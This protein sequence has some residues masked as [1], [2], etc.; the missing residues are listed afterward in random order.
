MSRVFRQCRKSKSVKTNESISP[1]EGHVRIR[2]PEGPVSALDG[3]A[4]T[5]ST[6][7][8]RCEVPKE[9]RWWAVEGKLWQCCQISRIR[10][11]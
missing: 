4:G 6:L 8:L 11:I 5:D 9:A 3:G 10:H 2:N 7:A 1:S